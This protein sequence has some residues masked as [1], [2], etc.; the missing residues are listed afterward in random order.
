MTQR[1]L[2]IFNRKFKFDYTK[3]PWRIQKYVLSIISHQDYSHRGC[4][5]VSSNSIAP[6][7]FCRFIHEEDFLQLEYI[8]Q[9]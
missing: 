5:T 1:P 8:Y 9:F 2:T 6:S 3:N 7:Y 4:P